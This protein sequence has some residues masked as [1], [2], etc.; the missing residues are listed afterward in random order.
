LR[1]AAV[2]DLAYGYQEENP[3]KEKQSWQEIRRAQAGEDY[4]FQRFAQNEGK[5][6]QVEIKGESA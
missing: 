6:F 3:Q 2:V 5:S 4:R 1:R